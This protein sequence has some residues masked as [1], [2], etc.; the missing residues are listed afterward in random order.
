M[1]AACIGSWVGLATDDPTGRLGQPAL[2]FTP[3]QRALVL[4]QTIVNAIDANF[5]PTSRIS[6]FL[7]VWQPL[8]YVWKYAGTRLGVVGH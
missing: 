7:S 5:H 1:V 2:V 6:E 8:F 4:F 3:F